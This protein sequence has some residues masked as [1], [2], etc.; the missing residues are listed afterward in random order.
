MTSNNAHYRL[1][2]LALSFEKAAW[3]ITAGDCRG[4]GFPI[5]KLSSTVSI[6]Y[7]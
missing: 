1:S 6:L 5:R 7:P 4:V 3:I 2:D